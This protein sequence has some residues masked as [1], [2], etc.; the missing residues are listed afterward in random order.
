V[1][2]K[3]ATI[4][5]RQRFLHLERDT[6]LLELYPNSSRVNALE[7]PWPKFLVYCEAAAD[8]FLGEILQALG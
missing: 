4:A 7:Q 5:D 6:A 1:T 2:E 3:L 8:D